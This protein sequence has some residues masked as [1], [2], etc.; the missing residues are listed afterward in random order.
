MPTYA[1]KSVGLYC[2]NIRRGPID[3]VRNALRE[4]LPSWALL[5]LDLIGPSVLEI[6]ANERLKDRAVSTLKA[7]GITPIPQFDGL[8]NTAGR[9]QPGESTLEQKTRQLKY[10]AHKLQKNIDK[11]HSRW[12]TQWYTETLARVCSKLLDMKERENAPR[13]DRSLANQYG[14]E[15]TTHR[16]QNGWQ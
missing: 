7:I 2:K 9:T 6:I 3:Q 14:T 16:D 8:D 4:C 11:T 5:G 1:A 15:H 10:T 12:A 13:T